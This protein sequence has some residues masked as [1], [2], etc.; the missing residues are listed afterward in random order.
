MAFAASNQEVILS[1][2]AR[3]AL[4][5]ALRTGATGT[6]LPIGGIL[7]PYAS[8]NPVPPVILDLYQLA[9]LTELHQG[10]ALPSFLVA[11]LPTP[12]GVAG[13]MVYVSNEV[14]GAVPAFSD[15]TNW[16]RVTDRAIVA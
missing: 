14:G 13:T 16:R 10:P 1:N 9:F 12:V 6:G 2:A 8:L 7:G 5:D 15:G 3:T 4:A 11:G